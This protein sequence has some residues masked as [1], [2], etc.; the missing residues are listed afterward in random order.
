MF[1]KKEKKMLIQVFWVLISNLISDIFKTASG[2]SARAGIN[3]TI[4]KQRSDRS[5]RFET[6]LNLCG[7]HRNAT[8]HEHMKSSGRRAGRCR[9]TVWGAGQGG[10]GVFNLN[11]KQQETGFDVKVEKQ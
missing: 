6:A 11:L 10:G 9:H 7:C 4:P 3:V 1:L 5:S 8:R 2:N